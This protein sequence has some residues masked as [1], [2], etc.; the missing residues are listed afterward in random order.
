MT[1]LIDV[2]NYLYMYSSKL[3]TKWHTNSSEEKESSSYAVQQSSAIFTSL[4]HVLGHVP[5]DCIIKG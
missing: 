5:T 3:E 1:V 2:K 4:D